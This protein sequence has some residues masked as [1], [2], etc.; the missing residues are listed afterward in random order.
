MAWVDVKGSSA[1]TGF[2]NASG[3]MGATYAPVTG[4][5]P[6]YVLIGALVALFL[7][8]RKKG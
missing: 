6:T 5:N 3:S 1:L 2:S 7:I 8:L 4:I